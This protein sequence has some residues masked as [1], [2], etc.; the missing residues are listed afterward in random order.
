MRMFYITVIMI[1]SFVFIQ[2]LLSQQP[3]D[4]TTGHRA[5]ERAAT[6]EISGNR[7]FIASILFP[8][9]TY[10]IASGSNPPK[11]PPSELLGKS[12]QYVAGYLAG[13][14]EVAKEIRKRNARRGCGLGLFIGL[15]SYLIRTSL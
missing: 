5:G 1:L 9:P 15:S 12:S 4:Y 11:P 6:V 7:W 8:L 14:S 2:P 10:M 13:Y 3:D